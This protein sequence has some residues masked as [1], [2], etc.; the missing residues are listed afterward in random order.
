MNLNKTLT[1]LFSALV[2]LSYAQADDLEALYAKEWQ[3]RLQQNPLLART[4][5]KPPATM[6]LAD[7]S[8]TS[9]DKQS[10]FYQDLAKQLATIDINDL[11][12]EQAVNYQ[13][14][15]GQIANQLANFKYAM[16]Q[17]PFNADSGFYSAFARAMSSFNFN[18]VED[19]EDYLDYISSWDEHVAQQ[20]KHMKMGLDR[21]FTQPKVILE[22]LPER[23]RSYINNDTE[24]SVF[25][26]P[27]LQFPQHISNQDRSRLQQRAK[28]VIRDSVNP[29]YAKLSDFFAEDY[30]PNANES[31]AASELPDGEAFYKNRIRHYTTLDLSA[32]EIHQIGLNEVARIRS[33][34]QAII[35]ETGF[36]GNFADFLE[37]LRTDPR[38]YAQTAEELLTIASRIAKRADAQMPRF[39][40][41]LPRTPYGVEAVPAELAPNYT[42]GRYVSAPRGSKRPGYY[43]VNTYAL[44]KRPL[45]ELEALTL[46]EAV[47]GHHHQ[48]A[49]NQELENLPPF[50]QYSYLSA[51]GEGWGL[52]SEW[53]GLEMGFYK[54]PY[55]N[56]GRLTYEMWRAVRLVVDTGMHAMGWS[57]DKALSYLADNTALS[58]HNVRTEIDRYI[59]WPGQALSYKLGELTIRRLRKEAEQQLAADFDIREFHDVVL[60]HGS[61]PLNVLERNVA[62][63]I[64]YTLNQRQAN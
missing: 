27:L 52:Y 63:Y 35:K 22:T 57:R 41:H 55:S 8:H 2:C 46:H 12:P 44:D 51:F 9:I 53:L 7:I 64:S 39:F 5:G 47:P 43:W 1:M 21:G 61:I 26:R 29:G 36:E 38:F 15:S 25:Y 50:R 31:I 60:R 14:F 45:Y 13:I 59:S 6:T 40:R 34:M 33:E 11:S 56:F 23:V 18:T 3:F 58:L 37:F 54:D 48:I 62:D 19:Y 20:I 24:K 30:V 17:M 42:T 10:K 4:M 32:D 28:A 49:L 16:Y